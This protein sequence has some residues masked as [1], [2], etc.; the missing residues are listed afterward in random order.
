MT[1]NTV[2]IAGNV[3]PGARAALSPPVARPHPRRRRR[4]ALFSY[5]D[6][7]HLTRVELGTE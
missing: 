2:T 5:E 4:R 3:D 1:D 7:A 6:R